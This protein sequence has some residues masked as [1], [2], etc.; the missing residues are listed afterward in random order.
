MSLRK[1]YVF[2]SYRFPLQVIGHQAQEQFYQTII[3]PQVQLFYARPEW[4]ICI[5]FSEELGTWLNSCHPEA[6]AAFAEMVARK[7]LEILGG[8]FYNAFI[9]MLPQNDRLGQLEAMSVWARKT[10]G[11]RPRG[12]YLPMGIWEPILPHILASCDIEYTFLPQSLFAQVGITHADKP[13]IIEEMGK[14]IIALPYHALNE[15]K[16]PQEEAELFLYHEH[17]NES[18]LGFYSNGEN[19]PWLEKF[20]NTL[21]SHGFFPNLP[22]TLIKRNSHFFAPT[23]YLP[24]SSADDLGIDH[25]FYRQAILKNPEAKLLYIRMMYSAVLAKQIKNDKS[26]KK[27]A[28]ETVWKAQN[29]EFFWIGSYGGLLHPRLRYQAYRH[30]LQ[31]DNICRQSN[32]IINGIVR[33]DVDTDGAL[34]VLFRNN[35]YTAFYHHIGGV[36]FELSDMTKEY[37][38]SHIYHQS[39]PQRTKRLFHDIFFTGSADYYRWCDEKLDRGPFDQAFY[40][41]R[42]YKTD[43]ASVLFIKEAPVQETLLAIRKLFSHKNKAINLQYHLINN[44]LGNIDGY[45]ATEINLSLLS[46]RI[47]IND[48]DWHD[49]TISE[50]SKLSI[51][52]EETRAE[53]EILFTPPSTI[54]RQSLY[55]H[56]SFT[57]LPLEETAMYQGEAFLFVWPCQLNAASEQKLSLDIIIK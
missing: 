19:T 37:H 27:V 44:A 7:Q 25:T 6:I 13:Y 4:H 18:I 30:L 45:F 1:F 9:P 29:H 11:R 26:R 21:S 46:S 36:L 56:V 48:K 31:S 12:A 49:H 32:A 53:I 17:T 55:N 2:I 34:E 54:W 33:T 41:L 39:Y 57:G 35:H 38:W 42:D 43:L 10:F 28:I 14:K 52:E 22:T 3:K 24:A 20:L 5:F 51:Y 15:G 47:K 40:E 50:V 16:T 8:T 23:L